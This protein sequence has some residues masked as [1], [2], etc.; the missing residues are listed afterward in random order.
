MKVRELA[1]Q[2]QDLARR[3]FGDDHVRIEV[4]GDGAIHTGNVE[5]IEASAGRG[6]VLTSE[7]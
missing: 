4:G 5:K 6:V 3:G 7:T 2:L 1:N